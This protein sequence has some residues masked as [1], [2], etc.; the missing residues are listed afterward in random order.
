MTCAMSTNPT[1]PGRHRCK[2]CGTVWHCDQRTCL[3]EKNGASGFNETLLCLRCGKDKAEGDFARAARDLANAKQT[4]QRVD[5]FTE[6][7][8]TAKNQ[9]DRLREAYSTVYG[10]FSA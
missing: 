4:G 7:A 8:W 5:H 2:Q 3:P 9:V 10:G 1:L 6:R